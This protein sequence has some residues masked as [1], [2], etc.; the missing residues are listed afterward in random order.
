MK[1]LR[2]AMQI[3]ADLQDDGWECYSRVWTK[4]GIHFWLHHRRNHSFY[5]VELR[6]HTIFESHDGHNVRITT[7]PA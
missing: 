2:Q 1:G 4:S 5:D 6:D 3:V 7:V